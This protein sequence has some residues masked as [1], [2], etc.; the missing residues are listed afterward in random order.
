VKHQYTITEFEIRAWNGTAWVD[1]RP[2]QAMS[3]PGALTALA[4]DPSAY[5]DGF[6]MNTGDGFNKIRLLAETSLSY[7]QQGQPGW[8]IPEQMGI[9]SASLFCKTKL[10]EEHCIDWAAIAPETN[11]PDGA[12]QQMNTVLYRITAGAGRVLDWNAQRCLVFPNEAVAE[13]VL[14]KASARVR[15]KMTTFASAVELRF[16]ARQTNCY[17]LVETR[18]LSQLQLLAPVLYADPA[19]PVARIEIAPA[20]A[21]PA[22]VYA[23]QID[24]DRAYRQLY[25][26]GSSNV[27]DLEQQIERLR[28]A[29]CKSGG[30]TAG[31][32]E[33]VIRDL[34][35]QVA[36]CGKELAALQAAQSQA[37]KDAHDFHLKFERCFPTAPSSYS[38]SIAGDAGKFRYTLHDD[39]NNSVIL[40]GAGEH[41]NEGAAEKA[42]FDTL[43]RARVPGS[44]ALMNPSPRQYFFRLGDAVSPVIF[45]TFDE[46][47]AFVDALRETV[48]AT[49][50]APARRIGGK[51]PCHRCA[52]DLDC[53]DD[54]TIVTEYDDHCR[55][56]AT[57][58]AHDVLCRKYDE[59]YAQLYVENQH[60]L[61]ELTHQCEELTHSLEDKRDDCAALSAQLAAAQ[62][63]AAAAA[64]GPIKPPDAMPCSTLLQEICYLTFDD[65]EVN[66]TIPG[67]AAVE[68]DYQSAVDAIAKTLTP[69]WRP[70]LKYSVRL[71]VMDTVNGTAAPLRDFYFGFR[72]AGQVGHYHTD[73]AA[74]Y[75]DPAKSPDQY[76]LTS[77]KGYVDYRRSYPD[78]SGNVIGAKPL[79]YE[80]ARILLFFTRRYVYHF[81]GSWPAYNGLPAITT[82]AMQIVIKDPVEKTSIPNPPPPTL[83]TTEIPQA[84]VSWP[85]DDDPRIPED[86]RTLLNLRNPELLD[87]NF[88]GGECWASGGQMIVPASVHTE[89][90]PKYLKALKLYTAIVQ[91]IDDGAVA[92]VLSYVFQTSRYADFNAQINSYRLDDGK[93]NQRDAVFDFDVSLTASDVQLMYDIVT[94]TMSAANAALAGRFADPF[95][96]L[97]QGVLAQPP[98]GPAIGTEINLVRNVATGAVVA[99]WIRNPEPFNDPKL[100]DDVLPRTLKVMQ[101]LNPD[102]SY[103]VLF[104]KDRAEAMVMH[105]S[106]T[107]P[108]TQLKFRFAYVE[109][110][111]FDYI[112]HT[113]V[114]TGSI[115]TH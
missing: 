2:Y 100:P 49:G 15:L 21:D 36:E 37:C 56:V 20:H 63:A 114:T 3:P 98:I 14:P 54:V 109:W 110:D 27:Q 79:F 64:G 19:K 101:G 29:T 45:A 85:R 30:I 35:N 90:I 95:D 92:E 59:L 86:V 105:L 48:Q 32:L 65:H 11:S 1:Y 93:G 82:N 55:P 71:Q 10:R 33:P 108:V 111:G 73:P 68:Q 18:T 8:Y 24:I 81:F 38:Y 47:R 58:S 16:F 26:T 9:T 78:P 76:M 72:T 42:L 43:S 44:Y 12:W 17:T 53:W 67:Q 113:I 51:R 31:D 69:I 106:N 40:T 41:L 104:S 39:R 25:E 102:P 112:D 99:V 74:H 6:W 22:A 84:V 66:L 96:R 107:I 77:L 60:H 34:Q 62:Q 83:I 94:G 87:P 115:P 23:L 88:E 5:K 46:L 52:S 50:F 4:A 80:D 89:V 13:V 7:M 57:A 28:A 91:S 103:G 70:H 97:V 61:D 75:V